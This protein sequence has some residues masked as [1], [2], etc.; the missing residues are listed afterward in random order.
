MRCWRG[1]FAPRQWDQ[2]IISL[3]CL[4]RSCSGLARFIDSGVNWLRAGADANW[5]HTH[6][7]IANI[8]GVDVRLRNNTI[9]CATFQFKSD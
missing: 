7:V 6:G 2:P 4:D 9:T 1:E 3:G 8:S 5:V